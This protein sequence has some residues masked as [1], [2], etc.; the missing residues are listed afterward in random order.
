MI[1]FQ[2][3]LKQTIWGGDKI[4][5]FKHLDSHLEQVGESWE[6]SGVKDNETVISNGEYAG[7]KL[8]D[9]V[10]ELKEKLVGKENYKRFGNVFPLL[11]KFIDA[12]KQLSIQ[13]HPDDDTAHRLGYPMGKTE[14]WYIMPSD[15]DAKLRSG[16]KKKITP[17]EYKEMVANDTITDAIAE[18]PV[19]EG[20][21]FFLPAG[22]IHSIG[23]GCFL[24]EIQQTS[25]VTFR[26]YDFKRK[27]KN[28][29][30]RQLHVKEAAESIDY[31]VHD[32]Y[33]QHYDKKANAPMVLVESKFF[34]TTLY[35]L[36]E[37]MDLDYSDLD[38]FVIL[39]G[40]GGE[41]VVTD[42]EGNKTTLNAGETILVSAT[43]KGLRVEGTVKFLESYV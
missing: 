6:I 13:V 18:Y 11:I 41:G 28:G 8:N 26:I 16:L 25:D 33:R 31:T 43:E 14:M 30:Y 5:P 35:D 39:I 19:K 34:T 3:L 32:D 4:I 2:P 9:L 27:D 10:A 38:S 23:A 29:N 1:K 36:T 42:S 20:D 24:A 15:P 17:E 40:V 12:R 37:P 22:R 7:M 21:C